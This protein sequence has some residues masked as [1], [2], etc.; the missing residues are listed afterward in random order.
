M[1]STRT[2]DGD[3]PVGGTVQLG[4]SILIPPDSKTSENWNSCPPGSTVN[5]PTP[6]VPLMRTSSLSE[7]S[8]NSRT[9]LRGLSRNKLVP[10]AVECC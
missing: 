1:T 7:S 4:E 8:R 3:Q 6:I 9:L 5:L 10:V 2:G